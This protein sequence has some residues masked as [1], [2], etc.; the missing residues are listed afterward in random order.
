[1]QNYPPHL[2]PVPPQPHP[3]GG[4]S[5]VM[6]YISRTSRCAILYRDEAFRELG[7]TG[8]QHNYVSVICNHPGILQHQ[9]AK[10]LLVNKS[11]VT[12]QLNLLEQAGFIV[13]RPDPLSRR[14]VQV[15]PTDKALEAHPLIRSVLQQ[16]NAI[17]VEGLSEQEQDT[18]KALL[19]KVYSNALLVTEGTLQQEIEE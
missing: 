10:R 13:R 18:L 8:T 1:M 16:W 7:L 9:L 6:R 15:F 11:N 19:D 14:Q 17:L 3:Q 12:R 4:P 2:Q 5:S